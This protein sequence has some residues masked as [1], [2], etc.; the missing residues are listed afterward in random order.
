M[1][2]YAPTIRLTA[3]NSSYGLYGSTIAR[4]DV[5]GWGGKIPYMQWKLIGEQD[6]LVPISPTGIEKAMVAGD[7]IPKKLPTNPND[8]KDKGQ[9][10]PGQVAGHPE[11]GES[12]KSRV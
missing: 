6:V 8:I 11:R 2:A 12:C 10:G 7:P 4:D 5:Y 3:A 1:Y 9:L